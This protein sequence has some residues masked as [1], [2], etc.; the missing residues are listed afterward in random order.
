MADLARAQRGLAGPLRWYLI[1][2][3]SVPVGATLIAAL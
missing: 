1:A 2:L 3:L